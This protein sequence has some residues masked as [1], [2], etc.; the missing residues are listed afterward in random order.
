[1]RLRHRAI[2]AYTE[3]A[4]RLRESEASS[5]SRSGIH[6]SGELLGVYVPA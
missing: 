1:V 6:A 4:C 3:Y 5:R 2:V